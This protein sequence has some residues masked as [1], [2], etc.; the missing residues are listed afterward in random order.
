VA[1]AALISSPIL[2]TAGPISVDSVYNRQAVLL[3]YPDFSKEVQLP[4][5]LCSSKR[6]H[7]L[8]RIIAVLVTAILKA[9][10]MRFSEINVII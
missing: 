8:L 5:Q 9:I 3:C 6:C 7:S 4:C 1:I 2:P 10:W